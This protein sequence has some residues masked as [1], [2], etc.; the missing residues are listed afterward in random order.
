MI[1][2]VAFATKEEPSSL[3]A[4]FTTRE[5]KRLMGYVV[6]RSESRSLMSCSQSCLRNTWCT[7]TNFKLSS[8]KDAKGTCELNKHDISLI[9]ENTKFHEEEGVTFSMLLKVRWWV[10]MRIILLVK[11]KNIVTASVRFGYLYTRN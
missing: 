10:P 6:K 8:K 9:N 11:F 5:N 7:S 2:F 3:T 1:Y 4:Y